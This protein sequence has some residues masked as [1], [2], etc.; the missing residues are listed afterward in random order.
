MTLESQRLLDEVNELTLDGRADALAAAEPSGQ[1]RKNSGRDFG[2]LLVG[3]LLD[4]LVAAVL[5]Q[6]TRQRRKL[7]G[8]DVVPGW[9]KGFISLLVCPWWLCWSC[10]GTLEL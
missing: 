6:L 2:A 4:P 3:Q 1:Q 7:D 5:H 10:I 8:V 9:K